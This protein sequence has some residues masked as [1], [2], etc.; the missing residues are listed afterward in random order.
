MKWNTAGAQGGDIGWGRR[1]PLGEEEGAAQMSK[2]KF[3]FVD[4]AFV[5]GGQRR[6]IANKKNEKPRRA[7]KGKEVFFFSQ[8]HFL[9]DRISDFRTD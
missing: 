4:V 3:S 5:G 9:G 1:Q 8:Q 6:R 7:N 2:V